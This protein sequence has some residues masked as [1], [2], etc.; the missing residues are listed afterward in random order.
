VHILSFSR[1]P[2]AILAIFAA[3]KSLNFSEYINSKHH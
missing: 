3:T 1:A 2:G